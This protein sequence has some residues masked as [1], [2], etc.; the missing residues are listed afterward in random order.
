MADEKPIGGE[1]PRDEVEERLRKLQEN[2]HEAASVKLPEPPDGEE[3]ERKMEAI[4]QNVAAARR[5]AV[6]SGV[7][8]SAP[9][10]SARS[11]GVGLVIAYNLA[12]CVL[13]GLGI[14]WLIGRSTGSTLPQAIGTLIGAVVGLIGSIWMAL[15]TSR[16]AQR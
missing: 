11:A 6:R 2:V 4:A 12:A 3:L 15:R 9:D 7:L 14:G 5:R 1:E 13:V 8:P 16:G 10:A